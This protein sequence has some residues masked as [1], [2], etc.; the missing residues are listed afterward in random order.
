MVLWRGGGLLLLL[1]IASE[2]ELRAYVDPSSGSLLW[3]V[4]LAGAIGILYYL[5]KIMGFFR[6]KDK[7]R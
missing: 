2:R 5:R 7:D 3:Q 4:L 1:L 6:K